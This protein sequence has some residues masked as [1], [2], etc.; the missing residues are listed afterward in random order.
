[1]IV[2]AAVAYSPL[3]ARHPAGANTIGHPRAAPASPRDNRHSN[4]VK[5]TPSRRS[6]TYQRMLSHAELRALPHAAY[7]GG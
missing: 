1:M 2:G 3:H 6:R 4:A 5:L 7:V